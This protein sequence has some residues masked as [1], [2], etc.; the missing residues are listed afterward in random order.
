MEEEDRISEGQAGFR[1]KRGFV[2]H[3]YTLGRIVQGMKHA[4]LTTYCCFL[5]VQKAYDTAWR[6]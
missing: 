1:P 2:D 6:N 5:D 3:V 4:G